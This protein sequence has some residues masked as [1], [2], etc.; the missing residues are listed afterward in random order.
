MNNITN[1]PNGVSSFGVPVI[2]AGS[3]IPSVSGKYIFVDG[4]NGSDGNNGDGMTS[5]KAT[6]ASA[7]ASAVANDCVVILP[8]TYT[9]AVTVSVAGVSIVGLGTSVKLV[10]WTSATDTASLTLAA[11]YTSVSGIYFKAPVYT[12][13]AAVASITLSS[14]GYAHIYGNQFQGQT[15]SYNAIYSPVCNSDNVTIENNLFIYFNTS[16]YGAAILGVEAGGLSYS[17]WEILNNY[18]HS[19]VTE[20][21][22]NGRV[23]LVQGNTFA[24]NG[25]NAAGAGAAVCTLALDLSGTSS[26]GNNVHGNF[27][28]GAYSSTLYK[29]GASGDDWGGNY[30]IA[31]LTAANPA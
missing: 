30:N 12:A 14:A 22:I 16:T 3:S 17:G 4:T 25:I 5:A 13:S 28:G 7:V 1:F 10:I 6:I 26:Y 18:F 19:C 21:N 24:I 23:C 15:G 27:L 2:G 9:E 31:G 11:N 8:G 20:V 29:I